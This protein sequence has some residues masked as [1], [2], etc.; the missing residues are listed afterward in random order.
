MK[1]GRETK[2]Q[3]RGKH[4]LVSLLACISDR[5][6][7]MTA[8]QSILL[9][10]FIVM[11][12]HCSI[13]QPCLEVLSAWLWS[14]QV[15]PTLSYDPVYQPGLQVQIIFQLYLLLHLLAQTVAGSPVSHG[16]SC[17][18][19]PNRQ[20]GQTD[21]HRPVVCS[22]TDQHPGAVTALAACTCYTKA[23]HH[24]E[25]GTLSSTVKAML[26]Y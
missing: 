10:L 2:K 5:P 16:S 9:S 13:H 22:S 8:V 20:T 4:K 25:N 14:L 19:H 18:T 23:I 1:R 11:Q 3:S 26:L 7:S 12:T 15:P 21:T 6:L 17:P 24:V